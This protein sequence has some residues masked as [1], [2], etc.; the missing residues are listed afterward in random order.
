MA[1]SFSIKDIPAKLKLTGTTI[2]PD[3][4]QKQSA[5][6]FSF[7]KDTKGFNDFEVW[8]IIE[9]KGAD[10]YIVFLQAGQKNL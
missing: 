5:S 4:S 1:G 10:E 8:V 3:F 7:P 6:V 2:A 9:K